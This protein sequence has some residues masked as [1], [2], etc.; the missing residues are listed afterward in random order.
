MNA[1]HKFKQK[2]AKQGRRRVKQGAILN[3]NNG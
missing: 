2:K 3:I 1:W